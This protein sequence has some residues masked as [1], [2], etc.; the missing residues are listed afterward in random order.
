MGRTLLREDIMGKGMKTDRTNYNRIARAQE[1]YKG[2][3][4]LNVETP[5]MVTAQ[6]IRATLPLGKTMMETIRGVL[7]G[8]GEQGFIQTMMD[9]KL[10][11]GTY[12]TTTPCFQDDI[13]GPWHQQ[14]TLIVYKPT[15][16]ELRATYEKVIN[17]AMQCFFEVSDADAFDAVQSDA[18]FDIRFN[19][20][21][22]GSY[23][24][25][26]MGEH[27]W[28]YGTGLAEPRFTA[29]MH[30][31]APTP[32]SQTKATEGL[33]TPATATPEPVVE[34]PVA[35]QPKLEVVPPRKGNTASGLYTE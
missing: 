24:V 7:V 4:Y 14:I 5:W 28:V 23:G 27:L 34:P 20:I 13:E 9:G 15:P 35:E 1:F 18:G 32:E 8:S 29:A 11:P 16:A 12:Q 30:S 22:L 25:R 6:A 33:E 3:G 19:E 21:V 31:L 10:E 26:Q 17:D 2:R